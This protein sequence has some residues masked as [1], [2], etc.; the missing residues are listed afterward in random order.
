[1]HSVQPD[2]LFGLTM[3]ARDL[4]VPGLIP[5]TPG[6]SDKALHGRDYLL[7][8]L[9]AFF[10]F[11]YCLVSGKPLTMHEARLPQ[12]SIEMMASGEWLLPHSGGRPWLERPPFPHWFVIAVG[13][14]FGRL[15]REWI[16]RI[17]SVFMGTL[18]LMLT[19]WMTTRLL[20]RET[21]LPSALLLATM[22][23]FYFYSGQAED[24]IFLAALVATCFALFT[25][26]EFP[27]RDKEPDHRL[28]FLGNRPLTVWGF[29]AV[30]GM[31]NLAKGPL[32]GAVQVVSTV[33]LF[34]ILGRKRERIMRYV[35]SWGWILFIAL[36]VAWPVVAYQAYPSVLDNWIYDYHG[37]FG[38]E[39]WWYYLYAVLWTTAPWT[40]AV[41][42]GFVETAR[43]AWRD[44]TGPY[45]F[46]W[47]WGLAPVMILSIPARKHHH[48]LVQALPAFAAMAACGIKNIKAWLFR[49]RLRVPSAIL[50][51][52]LIALAGAAA[53]SV[54]AIHGKIP[55]PLWATVGLGLTWLGLVAVIGYGWQ[56]Q[57]GSI[58]LGTILV[59]IVIVAAWGQ[60]ILATA[61]GRGIENVEFIRKAN[62]LAPL[63]KPLMIVASGSLDFFRNQYYSRKN[64]VLLHNV[65]FLRD[66]RIKDS[67][68]YVIG[69]YYE[70][71][72]IARELGTCSVLLSG[73]DPR[74][75]A[76]ER[77]TLFKVTFRP[78]LVRYPVPR[79]S[80]LQALER[81]EGDQAG[82]YCG[83]PP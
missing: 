26:T 6:E 81:G 62:E 54:A 22:Y 82:P 2:A 20:G 42:V 65:T 49:H 64:A 45:R 10:L 29:F 76:E 46:L 69:H 3:S 58:I 25:A 18:I 56:W 50:A 9:L 19:A 80:V 5:H 17:P 14:V 11:G 27:S 48:Y 34:L 61:P 33:G 78:D 36:T 41:L 71:H 30:L 68:V 7:I 37:P 60:S 52:V 51:G 23:E 72:F 83:P 32:V 35:W 39:P 1:M 4:V 57:N 73:K 53:L 63:D 70:R 77:W 74:Q 31:T 66:Q 21:G 8:G 44:R 47:C 13:H 12:T 16:V 38:R 59:G 55:G 79:V 28:H 40:I 75:T 67:E 15:D 24:D 43:E